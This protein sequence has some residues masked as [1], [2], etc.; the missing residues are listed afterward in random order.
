MN[1]F[2]TLGLAFAL[3]MDAMAVAITV[4]LI[5]DRLTVRRVFRLSFHFGLFQ[6]MMPVIGWLAGRTIAGYI[7]AY[8]HWVAFIMLCAVGG[9]MLWDGRSDDSQTFQADPTRSWLL[10]VLAVATS[11]DALAVGISL[12]LL[13]VSIWYPSVII[14]VVAAA[15]TIVGLCFGS[16]LGRRSGRWARILGG[17]VLIGLGARILITHLTANG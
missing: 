5:L 6:F 8:D 10:V 16:R 4:G 9:K 12:A 14:G 1:W 2:N 11:I 15:M 13:D 7:Q 17:V 3:A